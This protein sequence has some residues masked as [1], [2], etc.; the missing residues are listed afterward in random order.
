MMLR[1]RG[2]RTCR[3]VEAGGRGVSLD[4]GQLLRL[5]ARQPQQRPRHP[6]AGVKPSASASTFLT[7]KPLRVQAL[8]TMHAGQACVSFCWF[9]SR[10]QRF[11]K[12]LI[13]H[14]R[15]YLLAP[16][17]WPSTPSPAQMPPAGLCAPPLRSCPVR[18]LTR[19]ARRQRRQQ[20]QQQAQQLTRHPLAWSTDQRRVSPDAQASAEAPHRLHIQTLSPGTCSP[21]HWSPTSAASG[22][23]RPWETR[24]SS[25]R[26]PSLAALRQERS[27]SPRCRIGVLGGGQCC[28]TRRRAAGRGR[29]TCL[30]TP[31]T[32]WCVDSSSE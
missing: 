25:S 26:V 19:S 11:P 23:T 18:N 30:E 29:P 3:G 24:P 2:L 1:V 10:L 17:P 27:K 32:S 4:D 12:R 9:I 28:W 5:H 14:C 22:T 16:A 7:G 15:R 6:R 31:S 13:V 21:S 8:A 20:Q